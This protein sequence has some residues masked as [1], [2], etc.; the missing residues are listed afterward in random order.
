MR[1]DPKQVPLP[2]QTVLRQIR[3]GFIAKAKDASNVLLFNI[4][5]ATVTQHNRRVHQKKYTSDSI[6]EERWYFPNHQCCILHTYCVTKNMVVSTS[7]HR[8]TDTS[9]ILK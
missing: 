1:A 9:F 2:V 7:N 4:I 5:M 3:D 6:K 8:S